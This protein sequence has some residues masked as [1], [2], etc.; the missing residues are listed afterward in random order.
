MSSFEENPWLTHG[1]RT[2]YENAWIHVREDEVTRPDGAPGIYGVVHFKNRAVGV[3]PVESN[4]DIWLV[5]QYRYPLNAYSW[6]IPEGGC[7]EGEEP[8]ACA[9]RELAEETGLWADHYEPIVRCHLSNSVSDEWGIVYRATGLSHGPSTPD[10]SERIVVR[11]V[12]FGEALAMV[13]AGVITDS[14]SVMAILHEG[15]A[16]RSALPRGTGL[17][18]RVMSDRLAIARLDPV[19]PLP[20]WTAGGPLLAAVR[21]A[22]ELTLVASDHLVPVS[23]ACERNWVALQLIG[24]FELSE[25]GI[26]AA[27]TAPLADAGVPIFA[28]STYE[29]DYLL[30]RERD[31]PRARQVLEGVGHVFV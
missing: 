12:A 15:L 7:P 9:A 2:I 1:S 8:A 29:T 21:T 31:L 18:I 3:L 4:G 11:R 25:T 14:L 24:P 6:E 26:L 23:V 22:E 20:D 17:G 28:I 30:I 13:E 19:A 16:R 27:M 5:G 10:G